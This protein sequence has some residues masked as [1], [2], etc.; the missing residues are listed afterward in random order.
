M[1]V[2]G[3]DERHLPAHLEGRQFDGVEAY[4]AGERHPLLVDADEGA[5]HH[6]LAG[7]CKVMPGPREPMGGRD[8][9]SEVGALAAHHFRQ[10]E[11]GT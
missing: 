10:I 5:R 2:P 11:V 1:H 3:H 8:G 7:D 4:L 6:A 9:R